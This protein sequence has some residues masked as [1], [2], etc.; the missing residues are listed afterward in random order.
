MRFGARQCEG[1]R[2]I[3]QVRRGLLASLAIGVA[4][5]SPS[6]AGEPIRCPDGSW[7]HAARLRDCAWCTVECDDGTWQ[8]DGDVCPIS[9]NALST[10]RDA[11]DRRQRRSERSADALRRDAEIASRVACGDE[12]H[13]T[14]AKLIAKRGD[15]SVFVATAAWAGLPHESRVDF[16]AWAAACLMEQG[17]VTIRHATTGRVLA[18]YG[19]DSGY[20]EM[21]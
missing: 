12:A 8:I 5:V 7:C 4:L 15:G 19:R 2:W 20:E 13:E 17:R 18:V 21:D 3:W 14:H 9:A 6:Q 10:G 11:V 1:S 16:T